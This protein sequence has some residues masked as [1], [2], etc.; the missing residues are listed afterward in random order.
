MLVIQFSAYKV[1]VHV[2]MSPLKTVRID[3]GVVEYRCQVLGFNMH[4]N[5]YSTIKLTEWL[6]LRYLT[7]GYVKIG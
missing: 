7:G 4:S 3:P 5:S 6:N 2:S 1:W